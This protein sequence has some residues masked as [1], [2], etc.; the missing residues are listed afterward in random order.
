MRWLEEIIPTGLEPRELARRMTMA[1]LEAE[2]VEEV[3]AGWDNVYVGLVTKVERHPD[4]DR[5]N[6]VEVDA[7]EH[8]LRVVTGA[9]NIAEGQKVALA[10]AGAR[11]IDPYTESPTPV[12]KT[13][14]PGKIR[15]IVSEG[16]VC[17]ERELG[18]SDEHEGIMV[19]SDDAPV[20]APLKDWL[21]DTVIEF[22]ITPNLVHAFSIVGIAR[23]ASPLTGVDVRVPERVDL[24]TLPVVVDVVAVDDL[25]LC[26]RLAGAVVEGV[27]VAPA[28]EWLQRRLVHAGL[29]PVNNL[30]DITNYVMLEFGQPLHAYDRRRLAGGR[31]VAR[32]A[33]AGETLET[34]DHQQRAL[35][36]DTL[37]IADAERP[38]GVAGV[39]G[40]V[41]SE[42][43][44]DTT[45]ILLEAAT[46][47]MKAVRRA[48]TALKLRT[49]ASA[50]FERGLDP[51]LPGDGIARALALI[52]AV[53][54]DARV[55][56]FQ[57]VYPNPVL[58]WQVVLPVSLVERVLGVAIP[59]VQIDDALGRLGFAPVFDGEGAAR[60]LTVTVPTERRDVT[61]PED[62]VEEIARIVGYDALPETLPTGGLPAVSRDVAVLWQR[63]VGKRLA[64]AGL[65]EC[66]SYPTVGPPELAV[67]EGGSFSPD[68]VVGMLDR[69][70][71][72]ALLT[73]ANPIQAERPYLR[74]SLVPSLLVLGAENRKHEPRVALFEIG[75]TFCAVPSQELP[76]EVPTLG[77][78]M[79]GERE[80]TDRFGSPGQLDYFDAKG[81]LEVVFGADAL[82]EPIRFTASPD[83]LPYLHPGRSADLTLGE[84]L[85]GI[86]AELRPDVAQAAGF[87][88]ARVVVAEVDLRAVFAA[89]AERSSGK[90]VPRFLPAR[91]DFAIVVNEAMPAEDVR[92]ALAAGAGPLATGMTLFDVFTGEQ[93][94]PGRKS[95]A[96]RVTFEAPDRALTDA[97]L[98]KTRSRIEKVLRQRV[99][100]VLR[101]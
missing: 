42:V 46:F 30:V 32:R 8:S 33:R 57:D 47:D 22:E 70:P 43:A 40:G 78:V 76:D 83:P 29:R 51:N 31:I 11:L 71:A 10:L 59:E 24:G 88:G 98:V 62:V 94:G 20:G 100:G 45:E 23:Q 12:Y 44:D 54:P 2:Q 80:V 18:L 73:L 5:L 26:P 53:C 17:S 14:K 97:E 87:E 35:S 75:R 72:D 99:G 86:V 90:R 38:V 55:T 41:D 9:P 19:L 65:T 13:L 64:A 85:V 96:W 3:P 93:I 7:G 36:T 15:G 21:G 84:R 4:A 95:L 16:M 68:S 61:I 39:M 74:N 66:I 50:R 49:D 82:S 34:L 92:T 1:G 56:A 69:R 63:E 6:L 79:T 77:L 91:Q 60:R 101:G 52:L 25:D 81:I 67:L 28:P 37:V 58:P 48:R 27:V 89:Q